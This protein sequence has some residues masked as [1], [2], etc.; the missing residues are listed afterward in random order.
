MAKVENYNGRPT[1][2]IDGKPYP[3]M[4]AT[5][6]TM[7]D[8]KEIIFDSEYFKNLGNAGI[9]I[10]F[11]I[12]DTTWLKPNAIELFDTEARALLAAVPDAY[13]VPR[14][15]LHPPND[16]IEAHPE[17]CLKYSDGVIPAVELWT[18]SYVSDLPA[19]YSLC[20]S[21]WREDAGKALEQTWNTLM[22][23]PYADRIIGC[24]FAAGGTSEWYYI[25]NAFNDTRQVALDHSEAF[26]RQFT[27]YLTET[28]GTDKNLQK[29]WKNPKATLANPPIPEYDKHFF[30]RAIDREIHVPKTRMLSNAD[31]PEPPYNGT[32]VGSFPDFDKNKDVYD[33]YRAWNKGTAES[34]IYF[35][36]II[37]RLTPDRLV[38]AFYGSQGCT[39]YV[40]AGSAGGTVDVLNCDTVDFLAAPGVYEHRFP[41][42]F[43]GQREVQDSF[44]L[45]NKM[46]IVEQDSL[47]HTENRYYREKLQYYDL[48]DS[49]NVLKREF[50][51]AICDDVQAWWFDQILGGRRYKLP[52]IYE[53]FAKQQ[54]IA[55]EAYELDRTKKS[56]IAFIFDE[57]SLQAVSLQTTRD[58]VEL[59][60]NYELSKIGA[61]VDQYYHN[62][63]ADPKMPSYKL[64]VFI[65]V[66][67]LSPKEREVIHAKLRKD[68]ATALWLYAPGFIEPMAE[69]KKMSVEHIEAL[70][71][72]KT[73]M[74][75]GRCDAAFRWNGE[76][77]PISAP[78]DK[79]EVFGRFD[80]MRV[81]RAVA[82]DWLL[83]KNTYICPIFYS[84]DKDAKNLAYFLSCGH[85]AVSIKQC[86]GFTSI[87]YGSK[88]IRCDVLKE[89]ARFA[90]CHIFSESDDVVYINNNYIG[91][92]A[93]KSGK[94]KLSFPRKVSPYEVYE[95]KYYARGVTELEFDV[96]VGE[97][98]MFR[99]VPEK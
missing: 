73:D 27:K 26:K 19:H 72:I 25:I 77:H 79:R 45:H 63:M 57:E 33:F 38:G 11:L 91:F 84:V 39:N 12:C 48:T 10:Y 4:M 32:N 23:L 43:E 18:E 52:E 94:K 40:A 13:I 54:R 21:V 49:I 95:E 71:G 2:M 78:L 61:P 37:K 36:K 67:V 70:T 17:E 22:K 16:W 5:I 51:R 96:Y 29:H 82:N 6:R 56:E 69:D 66:Y 98:K 15:G 87:Y 24:F 44:T 92:H 28:Y 7:K 99:L 59:M 34:V 8:G 41:G 80:R 58:A 74:E 46:Y 85:P 60:R 65:N 1:I 30:V 14:I 68:N 88:C 81:M 62:D 64:Y 76:A 50:A 83:Y 90:G 97:T 35:S 53:L 42:G 75:M 47:T 89:V 9:K 20:S 3:P 93:S 31:A 86:D 55:H